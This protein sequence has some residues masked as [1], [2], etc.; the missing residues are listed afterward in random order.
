MSRTGCQNIADLL[1]CSFV[2]F[3]NLF[4]HFYSK[5]E[6]FSFIIPDYVVQSPIL[7]WTEGGRG[8]QHL[9]S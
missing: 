3:F 8:E 2:V 1:F 6:G 9:P 4:M 7:T 5:S